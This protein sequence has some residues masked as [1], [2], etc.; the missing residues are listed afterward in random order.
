[1]LVLIDG[2]HAHILIY[3]TS[4]DRSPIELDAYRIHLIL[5]HRPVNRGGGGGMGWG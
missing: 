3:K 5:E 4:E 2:A 1:M